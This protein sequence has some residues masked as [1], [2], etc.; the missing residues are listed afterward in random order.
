MRCVSGLL[1]NESMTGLKHQAYIRAG[2]CFGT[3]SCRHSMQC[4]EAQHA[5]PLQMAAVLCVDW[6]LNLLQLI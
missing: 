3:C 1:R 5:A 2:M 6:K 4:M